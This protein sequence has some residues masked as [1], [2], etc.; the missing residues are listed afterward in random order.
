VTRA[1]ALHS[2]PVRPRVVLELRGDLDVVAATEAHKQML[3]R[4]LPVGGRLVL[5]LSGVTFMDSTGIRLILQAQE[6]ARRHAAG[7]V[8]VRGPERV[9]RVLRLVGLDEQLDLVDAA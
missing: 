6:H 4:P 8:V 7:L 3:A 9:M 5:D 1:Q 2:P